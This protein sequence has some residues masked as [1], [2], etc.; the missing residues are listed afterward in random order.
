MDVTRVNETI[1]KAAEKMG[2]V[3]DNNKNKIIPITGI[4]EFNNP[5]K[6]LSACIDERYYSLTQIT[7]E[8]GILHT[9]GCDIGHVLYT[10]YPKSK[11]LDKY[12]ED[13]IFDGGKIK[14]VHMIDGTKIYP[15][16]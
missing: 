1:V 4:V 7:I 16:N 2:V 15:N 13:C 6:G 8:D 10:G 5:Y 12:N 3:I 11:D 9:N 14:C